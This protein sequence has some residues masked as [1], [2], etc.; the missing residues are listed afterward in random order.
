MSYECSIY[1]AFE[2]YFKL[3]AKQSF[4]LQKMRKTAETLFQVI[5]K[6]LLAEDK[7]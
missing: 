3:I 6:F 7:R 2:S 5:K 4:A 1:K